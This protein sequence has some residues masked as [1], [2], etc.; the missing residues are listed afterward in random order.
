MSDDIYTKLAAEFPRDQVS[1]RAQNVTQQ[2]DKAMALAYIDARDV[3]DRLDSVLGP[4]GWQDRYEVHGDKTICY[5]SIRAPLPTPAEGMTLDLSLIHREWLTKADGAG[6]TQ[7]EEEKGA[8]SGAFKRAA[9]KFG[10]GRYLYA[11]PTIWVPCDSYQKDGRNYWKKWTANP[12]D[13]VRTTDK[14]PRSPAGG[15]QEPL[16]NTAGKPHWKAI[17]DALAACTTVAQL[18]GAWT[19]HEPVF[20]LLDEGLKGEL[21]DSY[22]EFLGTL[23]EAAPEKT[24]PAPRSATPYNFDALEGAK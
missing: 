1:W 4:D 22:L 24:P 20:H 12:W 17:Y 15:L 18:K 16:S 3:M 2:G 13:Y 9:V 10:I 8:I 5:L 7:V 23:K 14:A 11:M 19:R 6:D 21:K